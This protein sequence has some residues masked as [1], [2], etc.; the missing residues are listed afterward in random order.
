VLKP[1]RAH[2]NGLRNVHAKFP[3]GSE[4]ELIAASAAMDELSAEYVDW[5]KDGDG[6]PFAGFFAPALNSLVQLIADLGLPQTLQDGIVVFPAPSPFHHLFFGRRQRSPTDAPEHFAHP[7]T[8][9]GLV[10]VWF[11]EDATTQSLLQMLALPRT[12]EP[13]CAPFGTSV[14]LLAM[15][16]G[17]IVFIRQDT[18]SRRILGATVAVASLDAARRV[19]ATNGIAAASCTDDALWVPPVAANGLWLEFRQQP[20]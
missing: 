19:L 9:F 10:R 14:A 11:A 1:G 12:D 2:A 7:N 13:R 5:L 18:P 6:A 8:A 17:E 20:R 16:E 15:T 4:L 3:D